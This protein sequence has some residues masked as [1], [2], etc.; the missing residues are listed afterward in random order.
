MNE[1]ITSIRNLFSTYGFKAGAIIVL[2]ILIVNLIKRPILKVAEK[3]S[4]QNGVD[5]SVITKYITA[6]PV[7]VAFVLDLTVSLVLVSFDFTALDFGA[8]I[9]NAVL[10][11]ALAIATY[12]SV[13]KQLEAYAASKNQASESAK[14]SKT[15][16]KE[17]AIK[18]SENA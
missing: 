6:L 11:G 15:E 9:A 13:K 4:K 7:A 5:K 17:S 3:V 16:V 12:E 8:I 1:V 10:Y 18:F 2:T 14:K